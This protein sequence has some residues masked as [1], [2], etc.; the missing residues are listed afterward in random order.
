MKIPALFVCPS[1]VGSL[2][3]TDR[4]ATTISVGTFL[5][6]FVSFSKGKTAELGSLSKTTRVCYWNSE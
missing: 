4:P 6:T 1:G 3:S 2:K 5:K